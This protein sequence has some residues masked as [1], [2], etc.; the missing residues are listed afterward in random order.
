MLAFFDAGSQGF[1][2]KDMFACGQRLEAERHVE[3]VGA[4]DKI[5]NHFGVNRIAQAGA[6]AALQDIE[7][8]QDVVHQ[9]AVGRDEYAAAAADVGLQAIPSATNF[10][11]LDAGS[12]KSAEALMGDLLARDIFVRKPS[13]APLDRC[14]RI[15]V[16]LPEERKVVIEAL[17]AS[18]RS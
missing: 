6:L 10:V 4:L 1:F 2:D 5:R 3:L 12:S 18:L 15:T 11:A 9:V 7:F 13:L 14:V 16:V 17:R 8:V